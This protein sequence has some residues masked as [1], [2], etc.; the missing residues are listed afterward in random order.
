[1]PQPSSILLCDGLVLDVDH[2]TATRG[3]ILVVGER[4]A[5]VRNASIPV[6]PETT[7]IDCAQRLIIPGLVNAHTHGHGSLGKGL[8]DLWT[9]ELLLNA[10]PWASGGLEDEDRRIAAALNAAEMIAKGVTAAYDM[11]TQIPKPDAAS[12]DAAAQGYMDV[13]L[14]VVLAP[15]MADRSFYEAVPGLLDALP[16]EIAR[17]VRAAV[18]V[19]PE[20]QIAELR[21]WLDGFSFPR[22]RVLPALGPTIPTHCTRAFLEGCRDLAREY[23]V[24]IQMHL[25]ES[26]PQAIAALEVYGA[27]LPAYLDDL[28]LLGPNFTGAHCV[29]LDDDDLARLRDAGARVV[30]NPG[31]NLRLGSGIARA[32]AMA[33]LGLT[34]AI[35]SDG[36]VSSDNQNMFEAIRLASYASRATSPDPADWLSAP[37]VLRMATVGGASVLG[38][39]GQLGRIA[40]GYQ[41]DLVLLDLSAPAFVPLN[42]PV[43]QLV[44]C[45]DSSAVRSVMIGGRMVLDEG[46]FTSIDYPRLCARAQAAAERLRESG[47]EHK[48]TCQALEPVVA[49]HCIGLARR[50]HHVD[51]YC[52]C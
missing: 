11:F 48:S 32:R 28:G 29:W 45:E 52:G 33:D 36:S 2:A 8:G 42:D 22:E 47:A 40:P 18:R 15:M 26:K 38:F 41:A 31:S 13:G 44:Q 3:D 14:R 24:G 4:I 12:L 19:S 6:G 46:R 50:P 17:S 25:A 23:D 20:R 10:A 27:S 43:T 39:E 49:A 30:H 51:R 37:E 9:L 34:V 35:G 1:M 21:S 7:R 16:R 5:D